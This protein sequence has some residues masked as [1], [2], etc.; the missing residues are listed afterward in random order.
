MPSRRRF[1]SLSLGYKAERAF[2]RRRESGERWVSASSMARQAVACPL[3]WRSMAAWTRFERGGLA[4]YC[5][6]LGR[7]LPAP[8]I[9]LLASLER[10]VGHALPVRKQHEL[11]APA[12]TA[13]DGVGNGLGPG[14]AEKLLGALRHWDQPDHALLGFDNPLAPAWQM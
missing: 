14:L 13:L 6:R 12:T 2:A 3:A 9:A 4:R 5:R 11:R 10:R 7:R 8:A 1:S